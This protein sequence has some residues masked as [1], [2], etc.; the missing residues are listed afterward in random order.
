MPRRKEH[1]SDFRI[2]VV[3]LEFGRHFLPAL[4][5]HPDVARVGVCDKDPEKAAWVAD[6]FACGTFA[7]LDQIL[8]SDRVD[9]VCLFTA[10]PEHADQAVAVLDS[11]KHCACAVPM[12][13]TLEDIHRIVETQKRTGLNYMMMETNVTTDEFFFLRDMH[14]RGEFGRIQF[15]RGQWYHDLENHPKYWMGLPPMHYTTHPV[16]P[17]LAIAG[18][19]A[20]RVCCFGSGKMRRELVENYGNPFP[21]ETAIFQLERGDLSMEVTSA[22]FHTAVQAKETFDIYGE[23]CSF[24]WKTFADD[25]HALV[26]LLPAQPGGPKTSPTPVFRFEAPSSRDRLRREMRIAGIS[27]RHTHL[28]CEFV[29]SIAEGRPPSIDAVTAADWTAPGI[30]AHASAMQDGKLVDVPSFR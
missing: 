14:E 28:A 13:T 30:C 26:R 22:V 15:L 1:V 19:R 23:K 24:K 6:D 17:M 8:A 18:S 10:I 9:A 4:L 2:A 12:A 25:R 16:A 21:V 27:G 5:A 29:D 11:G 20:S 3:G 7:D